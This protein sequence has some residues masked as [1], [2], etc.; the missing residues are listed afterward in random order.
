VTSTSPFARPMG[1]AIG[2]VAYFA[3]MRDRSIVGTMP[4]E[5]AGIVQTAPVE[6]RSTP[7]FVARATLRVRS[8]TARCTR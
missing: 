8:G 7:G 5:E 6:A 1:A 2:A 3:L 4:A